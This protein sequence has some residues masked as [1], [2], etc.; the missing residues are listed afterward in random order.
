MLDLGKWEI[1]VIVGE[2][3]DGVIYKLLELGDCFNEVICGV[4]ID[5]IDV[6]KVEVCV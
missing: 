1:D 3:L 4:L 5:V 2:L 6:I